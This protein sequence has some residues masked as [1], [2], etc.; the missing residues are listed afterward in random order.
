[1]PRLDIRLDQGQQAA[2][3]ARRWI[4][5]L[6]NV[7]EPPVLNDVRFLVNELVT[8]GV[9]Y[10]QS[11]VRIRVDV[12]GTTVRV[13]VSDPGP[14]F[15]PKVGVPALEQTSGRGLYLVD[16]IA[17]R[18]GVSADDDTTVWFEIEC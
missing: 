7:M 10:G 14:G 4:E 3:E 6:S 1:M 12:E 9:K 5:T 2:A 18:W 15:S 16:R 13:E 8:N 17:D 11:W